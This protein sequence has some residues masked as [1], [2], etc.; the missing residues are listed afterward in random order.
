MWEMFMMRGYTPREMTDT[1][2]TFQGKARES[3]Q[4]IGH[5]SGWQH[6]S[7]LAG[8]REKRMP[9][10]IHPAFRCSGGSRYSFPYRLIVLACRE[11]W[12]NEK[13]LIGYLRP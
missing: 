13:N 6:F 3:I 4:T 5:W 8:S 7:D 1:T 10:T 12:L 2:A 9:I 11:V